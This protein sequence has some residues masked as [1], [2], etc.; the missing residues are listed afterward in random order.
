MAQE[1]IYIS[2]RG[3]AGFKSEAPLELISAESKFLRG[4][5]NPTSKSFAFT[6][7]VNS[8][9][10]FNSDIQ[11]THFLENYMEQKKYPEATFSGK[12]IEDIPFDTPGIYTVRA[13]GDLE[14]HGIKKERIIKGTLTIK[15][16]SAHIQTTFSVPVADHGIAIPKIV[17]QKI[18][19]QISV[20][21]D[22][23]FAQRS[24]S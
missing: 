14:I 17:N 22:I 4:A 20:H 18:A 7:S 23:E 1:D 21:V 12:I 15:E 16:H 24:K 19:E 2:E 8:F 9:Q 11:R 6:I 3:A 13:K 5:I 10:G